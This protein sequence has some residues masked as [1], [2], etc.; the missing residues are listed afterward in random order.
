MARWNGLMRRLRRSR[1]AVMSNRAA[2][3]DRP[4]ASRGGN[5][6]Q[7]DI[8][9]WDGGWRAAPRMHGVLQRSADASVTVSD[10]LRFRDGLTAWQDLSHGARLGHAV[11]GEGPAGVM[12]GLLRPV[13]RPAHE[14][15]PG[16]G[17]ALLTLA[18]PPGEHSSGDRERTTEGASIAAQP[19][20]PVTAERPAQRK[21]PVVAEKGRPPITVARS[22]GLPVR[23][24]P[25]VQPAQQ[26][27]GDVA[28][29]P[30]PERPSTRPV[31]NSSEDQANPPEDQT[32]SGADRPTLAEQQPDQPVA[33]RL[34]D[35]RAGDAASPSQSGSRL[36]LAT[37]GS[38]APGGTGTFAA[39]SGSAPVQREPRLGLGAPLPGL[40]PTAVQR[41]AVRGTNIGRQVERPDG[42][43]QQDGA[44][45]GSAPTGAF[46]AITPSSSP[47]PTR[48]ATASPQASN[49]DSVSP[50]A[51]DTAGSAP[52]LGAEGTTAPTEHAVQRKTERPVAPGRESGA[53]RPVVSANRPVPPTPG[54]D[55]RSQA[56]ITSGTPA[57]ASSAPDAVET[58]QA[59]VDA[60]GSPRALSAR[61]ATRSSPPTSTDPTGG[62]D[63]ATPRSGGTAPVVSR[64]ASAPS[65]QAP[66]APESAVTRSSDGVSRPADSTGSRPGEPTPLGRGRAA[67]RP[68]L[69]SRP[70]TTAAA[71]V[72][73][74]A[75]NGPSG[76]PAVPVRWVRERPVTVHIGQNMS[77]DASD[78]PP[79]AAGTTTR[80]LHTTSNRAIAPKFSGGSL[81]SESPVPNSPRTGTGT[82][83]SDSPGSVG[84]A[85]SPAASSQPAVGRSVAGL[86]RVVSDS[87][88]MPTSPPSSTG[89]LA[90]SR[91]AIAPRRVVPDSLAMPEPALSASSQPAVGRSVTAPQ[92]AVPLQRIIAGREPATREPHGSEVSPGG[93][94]ETPLV[95][96]RWIARDSA[97]STPSA[98]SAKPS[99]DLTDRA[100]AAGPT[101]QRSSADTTS[102]PA[103]PPSGPST[104]SRTAT[105]TAAGQPSGDLRA[106]TAAVLQEIEQRHLDKLARCLFDPI[107]RLLRAELR[108][109]REGVGRIRER[110][111]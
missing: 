72:V 11:V 14:V 33:E 73:Q 91:S 13:S 63:H 66:T 35:S 80:T 92:R 77:P 69:A 68:L 90:V 32:S 20:G 24:L 23:R 104:I 86:Q 36:P 28:D 100:V 1:G 71:T 5:T 25:T 94:P 46:R 99:T 76:S 42:T 43:P 83:V 7:G 45:G 67:I 105:P 59:P 49:S 41:S 27:T 31:A 48:P 21:R 40:P 89:Q 88:G 37:H 64:A 84:P 26:R 81:A 15:L 2:E 62:S 110:R 108:H 22:V 57:A 106:L 10:G 97:P 60:A 103:G 12:H 18:A 47:D 74:R 102:T 38:Q 111:R 54:E 30:S 101:V 6:G 34:A 87:P 58:Q 96:P 50:D 52:L 82:A 78:P 95:T 51:A 53:D 3:T 107:V 55:R 75:V 16:A 61:A 44:T 65:S 39:Q 98:G 93:V 19:S 9:R 56:P 8:E 85:P 79:Y 4:D 70:L 29:A 109:G 17:A